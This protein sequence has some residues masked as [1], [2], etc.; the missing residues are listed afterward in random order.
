VG[1]SLEGLRRFWAR[2]V[3]PGSRRDPIGNR[4]E[5][6][7]ARYLKRK[8]FKV[9]ARNV[10]VRFGEADVLCLAPDRRTV[11]VVEVKSRR[12][13]SAEDRPYLPPEASIT[14]EKRRKLT[15][16]LMHL[17]RTNRWHDR[18]LRVDAVAVEWPPEGEPV[19]RHHEGVVR[20]GAARSNAGN[21]PA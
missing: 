18:P 15:A 19:I 6:A 10:R 1:G 21:E 13:E 11:V 3:G 14:R 17:A 20:I 12:V 7:A 2:L 9:L 16:V 5:D 8:K 4:G